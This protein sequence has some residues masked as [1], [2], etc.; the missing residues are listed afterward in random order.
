MGRRL[1]R[2]KEK[3]ILKG[4]P[5]SKGARIASADRHFSRGPRS[6]RL[7]R[8]P[9]SG[10]D[11]V[12]CSRGDFVR[13]QDLRR[14]CRFRRRQRGRV[15]ADRRP[16]ARRAEPRQLQSP[17]PSARSGGDDRSVRPVSDGVARRTRASSGQGRRGCRRQE[18]AARLRARPLL[19]AAA[20]D[21]RLGR[22]DAP[23]AGEP[24]CAGRR[25]GG[26]DPGGV[27]SGDLERL[28][29]HR[30]R[31]ALPSAH[32]QSDP[33]PRG[34]LRVE[35][36]GEPRA[37]VGLRFEGFR[38]RGRKRRTSLLRE[39]G[40]GTRS[41]GAAPRLRDRRAVGRPGLSRSGGAR[42]H[43]IRAAAGRPK[44]RSLGALCRAPAI[45]APPAAPTTPPRRPGR[46]ACA[47]RS[48][49]PSRRRRGRIR[50]A[51]TIPDGRSHRTSAALRP[52]RPSRSGR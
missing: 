52:C 13:G 39:G 35:A 31:L 26:G 7:Q 33:R 3:L 8:A 22:R 37:A 1:L 30:R 16:A 41:L 49:S 38:R 19:H 29:R 47:P 21:Q 9:R 18:L 34:P 51:G 6:A 32:G 4:L 45:R 44:D 40:E 24:P 15:G 46:R 5:D 43:R 28:H 10:G 25:P 42:A 17:V 50:R 11:A 27:E 48:A 14:H 36:E 2:L 20:D 12:H 23:V